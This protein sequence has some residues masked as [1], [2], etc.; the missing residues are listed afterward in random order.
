MHFAAMR[1]TLFLRHIEHSRRKPPF[2]VIPPK[3]AQQVPAPSPAPAGQQ[4]P[5]SRG[6]ALKIRGHQRAVGH[7]QVC[8]GTGMTANS[9][10]RASLHRTG[11]ATWHVRS[12]AET[13]RGRHPHRTALHASR[14]SSGKILRQSACRRRGAGRHHGQ[15]RRAVALRCSR[16]RGGRPRLAGCRCNSESWSYVPASTPKASSK[17]RSKGASAFVVQDALETMLLTAQHMPVRA[18]HHGHIGTI[19]GARDQNTPSTRP[20]ARGGKLQGHSLA[21]AFKHDI[22]I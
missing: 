7:A 2:I 19:R 22:N 1:L 12:T 4:S 8:P 6:R 9:S 17:T 21:G 11:C 15:G 14:P 20:Q 5:N 10:I 18:Q 16:A 3:H 13:A